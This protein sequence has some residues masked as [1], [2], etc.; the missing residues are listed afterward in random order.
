[1]RDDLFAS[2]EASLDEKL[3]VEFV[4]L[5]YL[6]CF[7]GKMSEKDLCKDYTKVGLLLQLESMQTKCELGRC[8][9][10]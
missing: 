5:I 7:N 1:M 8:P 2:S 9:S 6:A 4:A 3:F 10:S